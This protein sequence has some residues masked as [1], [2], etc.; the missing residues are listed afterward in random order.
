MINFTVLKSSADMKKYY[1]PTGHDYWIE[2]K[3]QIAFFGGKLAERFGLKEFDLQSFHD[4]CDGILPGSR[5]IDPE[6]G[7]VKTTPLTPGRRPDSRAGWDVTVDGPKDLG[8]LMA[9]G[10]DDRIIP[11]VLER[12]GRDVM[13]MIERDAKTRVR[14]GKQ[15]TDRETGQIVYTGVLHT[16]ARPVGDKIDV[17]PHFHFLVANVTYDPVE[18]KLKALQLQPYAQNG[19]REARPFYTAYFNNQLARYM[20]E[21]GYEIEPDRRTGSFRVAGVP[22][23]M[24]KEFSQRTQKIEAVASQLEKQK[25]EFLGDPSAKLNAEVKGRLGAHTREPKKPG[26]TWN[27]LMQHWLSRV[28]DSELTGIEETVARARDKG[29]HN[30]KDRFTR[31]QARESLDW[32][33]RHLLERSSTVSEREVFTTALKH[34]LGQITPE[35]ILKEIGSRK[36]LIR[37]VVDGQE[38]VTTQAVLD[39]ENSIL[40]FAKKG[41]DRWKALGGSAMGPMLADSSPQ[42]GQAPQLGDRRHSDLSNALRMDCT[43][44]AIFHRA[45]TT[46]R[47]YHTLPHPASGSS[48]RLEIK[49]PPDPDPRRGGHRQDDAH[50]GPAR[51]RRCAVCR[52]GPLCRSKSWSSAARESRPER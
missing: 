28:A 45:A 44:R 34:G 50:E 22:E 9:L 39:E 6:T 12:A 37:R 30:V 3:D 14:V 36:D 41:R 2:D 11:E 19:A 17:Q 27:S 49:R 42:T 18:K 51:R 20:Q 38:M 21:L 24:R 8:V 52:A 29:P 43:L 15:D 47:H 16:T 31:E 35:G 25:Q 5:R 32:A 26:K 23:R 4:L 48:P 40:A 13:A 33:L 10:L 46:G 1:S 7:E